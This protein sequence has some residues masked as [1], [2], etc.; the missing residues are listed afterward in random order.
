MH[1]F[2]LATEVINLVQREAQKRNAP[3]V[4]EITIE[5]GSLSGVEAGAF[6]SALKLLSEGSII[7]NAGLNILRINGI[8]VCKTCSIEFEMMQRME[9]CPVC[10]AF[11]SEI[12]GGNEFRVISMTIE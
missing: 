6:E 4:N 8:G 9:S 3:V 1:E 2:S 11:P 10:H 12:N 7:E 5:V